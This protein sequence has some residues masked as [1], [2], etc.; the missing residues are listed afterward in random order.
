MKIGLD[1]SLRVLLVSLS[2][3]IFCYH[4][5]FPFITS[6]VVETIH[7]CVLCQYF[8]IVHFMSMVVG[9]KSDL[10]HVG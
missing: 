4:C 10:V 5:L 7:L 9:E 8:S 3:I 6:V 2:G 1:T